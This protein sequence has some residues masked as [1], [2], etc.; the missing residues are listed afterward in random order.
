MGD[1]RIGEVAVTP[2]TMGAARHHTAALAMNHAAPRGHSVSIRETVRGVLVNVVA[3]R[4][5]SER[6]CGCA[7]PGPGQ[8]Q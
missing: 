4:A 5:G 3:A 7:S 2:S 1:F 6:D 8:R